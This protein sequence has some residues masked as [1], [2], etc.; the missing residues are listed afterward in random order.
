[1]LFFQSGVRETPVFAVVG[2]LGLFS[3]TF[4]SICLPF[5]TSKNLAIGLLLFHRLTFHEVS[6]WVR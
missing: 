6:C 3:L 2:N 4:E 5:A 1:M